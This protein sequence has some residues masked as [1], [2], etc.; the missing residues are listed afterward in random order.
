M[1]FQVRASWQLNRC[2]ECGQTLPQDWDWDVRSLVWLHDLPRKISPTNNDLT[3]HDGGAG[4]N[5]FLH[6]EFK[7]D[8]RALSI[9]QERHLLGLSK[10]DQHGVL[11]VRGKRVDRIHVQQA[12][13]GSWGGV[14]ETTCESL[15][16]TISRWLSGSL[17]RDAAE[18]L[19][20]RTRRL[21]IPAGRPGHTH[22]FALDE[23]IWRCVQDFY[24]VGRDP[25]S[26]CGETWAE[27][28]A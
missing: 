11:L 9:G 1:T 7:R 2:P 10:S 21:N 22:G 19:M 23:G 17:W 8:N 15:N 20:A 27:A 6:L 4:R 3:I 14:L 12:T 16:T 25:S 13:R 5:R 28:V 24:A 26:G 18:T